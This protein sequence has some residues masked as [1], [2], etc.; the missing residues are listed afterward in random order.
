MMRHPAAS[1]I[2]SC[3]TEARIPAGQR[4][5]IRGVRPNEGKGADGADRGLGRDGADRGVSF[6]D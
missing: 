1:T 2:G 5:L 4:P 6:T 3:R